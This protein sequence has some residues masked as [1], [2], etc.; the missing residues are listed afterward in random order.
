M[1][2]RR[3][4]VAFICLMVLAAVSGRGQNAVGKKD[5]D[6]GKVV[7][8]RDEYGVPHIF[9]PTFEGGAMRSDM[10]RQRIGWRSY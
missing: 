5:P 6:A 7:V 10:L 8:Y 9:A 1:L 4:R 3:A 2:N